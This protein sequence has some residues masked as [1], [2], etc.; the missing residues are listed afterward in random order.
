[1]EQKES[2]SHIKKKYTTRKCGSRICLAVTF[3]KRHQK[4]SARSTMKSSR[5]R[6]FIY[7][8]PAAVQEMLL[9]AHEILLRKKEA[10]F[11]ITLWYRNR[12]LPSTM[13]GRN[14]EFIH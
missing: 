13:A 10:S 5:N 12:Y 2:E 7:Q 9:F 1:M 6:E 8:K 11:K 3:C 14:I 4:S